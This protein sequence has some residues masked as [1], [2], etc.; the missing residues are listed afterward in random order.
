M[1]KNIKKHI[2]LMVLGLV[3]FACGGGSDGPPPNEPPTTAQLIFP[4]PDLLCIDN[5]ITFDW[6]D[7]TDPEG[8]T[9][10]YEIVIARDRN[11]TQIEE[12]RS[13][14]Q[15]QV[16]ITLERAV[17]FY[18]SVTTL[19]SEGAS[20]TP[21]PT[22]AFYTEGDGVANYAPFTAALV[23]PA[24]E[25]SVDAGTVSLTW[26]GGDTDTEDTLTYE[27]FF[28]TEVDPPS[29]QTGIT[30]ETFDVTVTSGMTYYWRIDTTDDSGAKSIG[31]IWEFTVN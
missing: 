7:A 6:S 11:L 26:M 28:G 12:R 25:G 13:V 31:Q 8:Q 2:V 29:F 17:A 5:N 3:S 10:R 30:A 23:S 9:V 4:S 14:N 16:T 21:T 1:K 19:D 18:W 27:L 24:D 22:Q 15:S 20:S